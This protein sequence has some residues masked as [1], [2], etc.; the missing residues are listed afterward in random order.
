MIQ[1]DRYL[2]KEEDQ[3]LHENISLQISQLKEKLGNPDSFIKKGIESKISVIRGN[4]KND[5]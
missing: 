3:Y 1:K 5:E 2:T 4:D